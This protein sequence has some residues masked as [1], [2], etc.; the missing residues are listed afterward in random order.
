VTIKV[1][2]KYIETGCHFTRHHLQFD[3]IFLPFVHSALQVVY[4]FIKMYSVLGSHF[5]F[6][7]LSMHLIL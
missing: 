1:L 4:M 5:L 6:D 3:I 2:T 7:K